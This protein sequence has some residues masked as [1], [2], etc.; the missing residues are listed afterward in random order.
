MK[1]RRAIQLGRLKAS[2]RFNSTVSFDNENQ[3]QGV[4]V[5]SRNY[6]AFCDGGTTL[7]RRRQQP[8]GW[9]EAVQGRLDG[10]AADEANLT[11]F[12]FDEA[13]APR[14]TRKPLARH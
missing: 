14:I 12:H 1:R 13:E 5:F 2:G 6:S 8:R 4:L 7:G 3:P 11:T 9:H 10:F